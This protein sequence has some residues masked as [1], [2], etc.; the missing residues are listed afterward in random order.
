M[1]ISPNEILLQHGANPNLKDG[2]GFDALWYALNKSII[3]VDC[4]PIRHNIDL[5][6]NLIKFGYNP[7][8]NINQLLFAIETGKL[9]VTIDTISKDRLQIYISQQ[10]I[11]ILMIMIKMKEYYSYLSNPGAID[12]SLE[13]DPYSS[14]EKH[15]EHILLL[16]SA[17][18]NLINRF[19]ST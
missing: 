10:D 16:R 1:C 3:Y 18:E 14:F 5:I 4:H 12:N 11:D 17:Y 13:F 19:D 2:K 7:F 15:H 6:Q 9:P 8:N